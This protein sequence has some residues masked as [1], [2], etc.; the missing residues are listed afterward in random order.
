MSLSPLSDLSL[1]IC[2]FP[3]E[4]DEKTAQGVYSSKTPK[5]EVEPSACHGCGPWSCVSD[6]AFGNGTFLGQ[7]Q[8]SAS[9]PTRFAGT[10]I[11]F[12]HRWKQQSA[13]ADEAGQASV[14]LIK[15]FLMMEE[16]RTE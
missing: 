5:P 15:R 11:S 12:L 8:D 14:P 7:S 4:K 6:T 10:G 16:E 13:A 9:G 1:L 2:C 3:R